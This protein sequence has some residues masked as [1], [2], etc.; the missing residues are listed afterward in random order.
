META[1]GGPQ[2]GQRSGETEAFVPIA[3]KR[4]VGPLLREVFPDARFDGVQLHPVSPVSRR[5]SF[6]RL[7][8]PVLAATLL[9]SL[10]LGPDWLW[11]LALLVPAWLYAGAEYRARGWARPGGHALVRGGVLTR[12]NWVVPEEKIQTLHLHETPFQRR[13][14]LASLLIDTAAGGRVARVTDLDRGSAGLLL[15]ELARH[16][17]DARRR[18]LHPPSP[19]AG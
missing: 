7:S 16:A 13:L 8:V 10:L 6:L 12:V 15:H 9:A 11:L 19:P 3:R 5:R 17:G 14:G 4:D 2:R 18:A 1:G